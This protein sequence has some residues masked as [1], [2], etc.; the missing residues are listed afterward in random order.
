M[1]TAA[2]TVLPPLS[3]IPH[4]PLDIITGALCLFREAGGESIAAKTAVWHVILNRMASGGKNGWGNTV[5][6]VV[7]QPFQFS[8]FNKNDPN[9]TRWPNE[10]DVVGWQA[11]LDCLAVVGTNLLADPTQGANFYHDVSILPPVTAWLGE[12]ATMEELV[13]K[14]TVQVGRLRF[15]KL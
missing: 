8:S 1:S 3:T 7:T 9:V 2:V 12:G 4:D 5:H 14:Q 6:R 11:W 10:K 15:Y 13:S